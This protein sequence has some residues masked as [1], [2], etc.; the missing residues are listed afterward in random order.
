[1]APSR[2]ILWASQFCLADTSSGAA[3]SARE[4]LLQLAARG[5]DILI[6]GM[7]VFDKEVGRTTIAG[8]LDGQADTSSVLRIKDGRLTHHLV[9]TAD[10]YISNVKSSEMTAF[11]RLYMK[12]LTEFQPDFVW[13]YGG[14][15][16]DLLIPYE[17]KRHGAHTLAYLPNGAYHGTHWCQD[18]DT[19]LTN[20]QA[21]ADMYAERSGI[22]CHP[23]GVFVPVAPYLVEAPA[24]ETVTF[25]NPSLEKGGGLVAQVA[26]HMETRR[27][28]IRFDIVESR[29]AWAKTL[30]AVRGQQEETR[31]ALQNVTVIGHSWDMRPVYARAR[32]LLMPSLW[33][34]AAGRVLVEA[35]IN[36]IPAI[37]SDRGGP[38]TI[39][40]EA[41]VRLALPPHLHEPPYTGLLS[42]DAVTLF[43]QQI[44][45]FFDD[46]T[47]FETMSQLCRQRFTK[48]HDIREK[49]DALAAML[50]NLRPT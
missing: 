1:M 21:T 18:V 16:F 10:G 35:M 28:D 48:T 6:L 39:I 4:M 31:P 50:H 25:I 49:G 27:P 41:G 45:R 5:F 14:T 32:G 30:A 46:Q 37:V 24:Y 20:T 23:V 8:Q 26:M 3:Q 34:E 29:G 9:Q 33:W 36:G 19:I 13:T 47:Y 40:G 12:A 38:P 44:E 22:T 2:K 11:M 15:A 43:A 17:G 7:T 42:P